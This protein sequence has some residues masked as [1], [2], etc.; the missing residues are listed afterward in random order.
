MTQT[1]KTAPNVQIDNITYNAGTQCFE[2]LVRV[3]S[4]LNTAKYPCA[5]QAPITLSLEEASA[6]LTT[7]ALRRHNKRNGLYS[8][9]RQ[10][11]LLPRAGRPS[12]DPRNWLAQ[13]GFGMRDKAA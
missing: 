2:A 10:H 11:T 1:V 7:Q 6:G 9:Q 13:L 5:I 12:Y 4:T 3:D 8:Q